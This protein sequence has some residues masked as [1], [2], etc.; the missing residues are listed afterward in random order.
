MDQ[1]LLTIILAA[2]GS[3]GFFAFLQF[4]IGR[5]DKSQDVLSELKAEIA[6]LK[7][8]I[9][10]IRQDTCRVQLQNLIQH[11]PENH[12]AIVSVGKRYFV[13]LKGNWYMD[14]AFQKWAE[15][16]HVILPSW[17]KKGD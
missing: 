1:T 7:T 16:E 12:D 15:K 2:L 13:D 6:D 9:Q 4:L 10:E 5:K 3:S 11:E 8:Q 17:F 14:S